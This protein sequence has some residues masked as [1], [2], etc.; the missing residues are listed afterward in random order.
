MENK[1][2]FG[3]LASIFVLIILRCFLVYVN[4]EY[5]MTDTV[6]ESGLSGN[7]DQRHVENWHYLNSLINW[8]RYFLRSVEMILVIGALTFLCHALFML[9]EIK[10][11]FSV[12]VFVIVSTYPVLL[13]EE[14]T[15]AV[16][17]SFLAP[18]TYTLSD[19]RNFHFSSVIAWFEPSRFE[20][21]EIQ[22]YRLLGWPQALFLVLIA[23]RFF[24]FGITP[25]L[26][27]LLLAT[28][29]CLVTLLLALTYEILL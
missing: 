25:F 27:S 26:R 22:V 8:P 5:I 20:D 28:T 9:S 16:W 12:L 18:T 17:F 19:I 24:R 11:S 10:F 7:Y 1:R 6:V 21:W 4:G 13:T 2:F 23:F 14:I 15:K 29:A 3:L